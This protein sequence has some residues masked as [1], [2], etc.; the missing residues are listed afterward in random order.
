MNEN[1]EGES[2]GWR[3]ST[4]TLS[5]D[6]ILA[7]FSSDKHSSCFRPPSVASSS[8]SGS[9][10]RKAGKCRSDK[11]STHLDAALSDI[12][13][14]RETQKN[15]D[16]SLQTLKTEYE[17]DH[18]D[19]LRVMEEEMSRLNV[20]ERELAYLTELHQRETSNLKEEI[21]SI[22]DIIDFQYNNKAE[23]FSVALDKCQ[24]HLLKMELQQQEMDLVRHEDSIAQI[25]I[26]KLIKG[27]L[28]VMSTLLVFVC[29]LNRVVL[30]FKSSKH[31]L[32][33][34]LLAVFLFLLFK[35]WDID[36]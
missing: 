3:N 17:R 10:S 8:K 34:V 25:T 2:H 32:S 6:K 13:Q 28:V 12:Q 18:N 24:S 9:S 30:I 11:K 35:Y 20:L 4:S 29:T 26:A 16:K 14:V 21:N 5:L 22:K 33:V 36:S 23:E 27:L 1:Q 19:M 7:T 15:L 31:I